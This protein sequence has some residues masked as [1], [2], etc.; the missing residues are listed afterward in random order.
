MANVKSTKNQIQA[1][2][3]PLPDNI[4]T[5]KRETKELAHLFE[6]RIDQLRNRPDLLRTIKPLSEPDLQHADV[7]SLLPSSGLAVGLDGSMDYDE[8]LEMLLFYVTST[9]YTCNYTL[10]A[11]ISCC[12]P[13]GRADKLCM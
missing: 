10:N 1:G 4:S 3:V 9:G 12:G 5:L 11:G 2:S 13:S 7:G 6:K 8:V